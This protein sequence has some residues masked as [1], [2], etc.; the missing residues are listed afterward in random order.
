MKV[1]ENLEVSAYA[2]YVRISPAKLRRVL[3]S[4]KGYSC[5]VIYTN[6]M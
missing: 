2:R 1:N 6:K 4:I 3:N 5:I